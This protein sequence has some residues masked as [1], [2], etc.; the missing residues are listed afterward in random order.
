MGI[1]AMVTVVPRTAVM[2]IGAAL[3]TIPTPAK[4]FTTVC[5]DRCDPESAKQNSQRQQTA[6]QSKFTYLFHYQSSCESRTGPA[7]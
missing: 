1:V 6:R 7:G 4:V 2:T 3:K 5:P